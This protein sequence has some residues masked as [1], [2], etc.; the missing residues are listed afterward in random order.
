MPALINIKNLKKQYGKKPVLNNIN[1]EINKGEMLGIIGM[2][3]SGKTTLL[4]T[5]IG[6]LEPEEGDILYYNKPE[7]KYNSVFENELKLRKKFGFATQVPSFY[8]KLTIEE[9]LD[10]FGSLYQ[11]NS[12]VRKKNITKLLKII[13]LESEKDQL[14]QKLSGGMEKRLGIACALIHNP[15]VIILDEPTANL[16]PVLRDETWELIKNIHKIGTTVIV[17][18]HLLEEL[19]PVCQRIAILHNHSL[20]EVGTPDQLKTRYTKD[21]EIRLKVSGKQD[22]IESIMKKKEH[23]HKTK[24]HHST[25]IFYTQQPLKTIYELLHL[26]DNLNESIISLELNRPSLKEVFESIYRKKR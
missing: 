16:D 7:K 14:A 11:L 17:A 15:E 18:S 21:Q 1:L 5:V 10:H 6:F 4:N 19:E 25:L 3:G 13:G 12:Q 20:I 22:R 24:K 2:S 26:V 9:N 8:P 23:I